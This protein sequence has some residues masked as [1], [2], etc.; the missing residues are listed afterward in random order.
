MVPPSS[1]PGE[2]ALVRLRPFIFPANNN[3]LS[4]K[5]CCNC[6]FLISSLRKLKVTFLWF[7]GTV[8]RSIFSINPSI[9][10]KKSV[11]PSGFNS[12]GGSV[13]RTRG[14][15][16]SIYSASYYFCKLIKFIN[17]KFFSNNLFFIFIKINY[18]L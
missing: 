10:L 2:K 7:S 15:P 14:Y 4:K 17:R 16:F 5:D 3:F 12:C 11:A 9:T 13:T 18:R 1:L 6:F 8:E